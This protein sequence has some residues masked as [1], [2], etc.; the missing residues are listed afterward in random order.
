MTS[1]KEMLRS[2]IELLSESEAEEVEKIVRTLHRRRGISPT[3]ARL[4]ADPMFRVPSSTSGQ[5]S[6]GRAARGRGVAASK[7]LLQDRR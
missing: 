2:A 6:P 7:L 1:A 4:A 3:L 5:F